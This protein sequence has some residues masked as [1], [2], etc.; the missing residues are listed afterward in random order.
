M[1]PFDKAAILGELA[2]LLW[3]AYP[4]QEIDVGTGRKS[5][6]GWGGRVMTIRVRC[7]IE[8]DDR[9]FALDLPVEHDATAAGLFDQASYIILDDGPGWT[10]DS[11]D[12]GRW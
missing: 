11:D 12:G 3:E 1:S 5:G 9:Y 2:R 8:D 4:D 7:W 6:D 10:V